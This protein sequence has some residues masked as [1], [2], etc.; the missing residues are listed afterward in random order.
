M[1]RI[2]RADDRGAL[3]A[4]WLKARYSFSFDQYYDPQRDGFESLRVFNHDVVAPGEGFPS[5]SHN[6]FEIVTIPLKGSVAHKDNAGGEGIVS[7]GEVQSMSA[8]TG[9][10]HS[11]YNAS[12]EELLE[13]FQ[14]WIETSTPNRAPQ[15]DQHAYPVDAHG[16]HILASQTNGAYIDT[17]AKIEY[18][19]SDSDFSILL[20][21]ELSYFY[22]AISGDT[23][24]GISGEPE[25]LT[26]YDSLEIQGEQGILALNPGASGILITL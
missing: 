25:V 23:Y 14:I 13:L 5:H 11:E 22:M 2:Q 16:R 18:L 17:D 21:E 15:Y 10:E 8:G 20:R 4:G 19:Y 26:A 6:N 24:L 1:I 12:T 3:N 9:V 7:V